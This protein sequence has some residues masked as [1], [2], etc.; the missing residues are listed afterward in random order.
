MVESPDLS[1]RARKEKECRREWLI[2]LCLG[3][4]A[5]TM[6]FAACGDDDDDGGGGSE[7]D[8]AAVED[9][10]RQLAESGSSNIDYFLEHSTDNAIDFFGYESKEDCRANA[11]DCIGEPLSSPVFEGTTVDGDTARTTLNSP[12]GSFVL[13]MVREDDIWKLDGI[14]FGAVDIPEGVAAVEVIAVE[15]GFNTDVDALEDGN[16]AFTMSNEGEEEH[17][18]IVAK[19]A[20]DFDI[21]EL[22]AADAAADDEDEGDDE[23]FP[24]GFEEFVGFTFAA[25]G[26]SANL[27]PEGELASGRYLMICFVDAPDGESHAQKGMYREFE[28]P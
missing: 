13:N 10:A 23:E 20:D 12:D 27:V 8:V 19:V 16:V 18:L 1:V 9:T 2:L 24:P 7:D 14:E 5:F 3:L 17:E 28:I 26:D 6:A 15:Y 22:L 25:P 4:V 11:D 21:E